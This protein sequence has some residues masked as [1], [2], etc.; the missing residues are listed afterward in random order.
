MAKERDLVFDS[1]KL[2]AIFLVLW[3]HCIAHLS[4]S[5]STANPL[6]RFIY[7]FHMP[8]FMT[9]VG[10]FSGS[11]LRQSFKDLII[12]KGR[13]LI[14]PAVFVSLFYLVDAAFYGEWEKRLSSFINMPWFLKSAFLCLLLHYICN[15]LFRSKAIA[16]IVGLIIS[17]AIGPFQIIYMYPNFIF[18]TLIKQEFD[19]VKSHCGVLS[20][21]SGIIFCIMLCFWGEDDFSLRSRIAAITSLPNMQPLYDWLGWFSYK[22]DNVSVELFNYVITPTIS[23]GL[24]LLWLI[25]IAKR[26]RW[27]SLLLLGLPLRKKTSAKSI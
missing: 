2:F 24:L 23:I 20:F 9:M 6:F 19:W 10:F 17:L 26:S 21:V 14:V 27:A 22:F 16:I 8:L 5:A 1:L 3:G 13:Q 7:S 11:V 25:N 4:D 12:N 15:K 18:G